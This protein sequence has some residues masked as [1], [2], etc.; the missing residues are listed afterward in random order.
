MFALLSSIISENSR[1]RAKNCVCEESVLEFQ[2]HS[3]SSK[4]FEANNLVTL[5]LS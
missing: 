5:L 3:G 4:N 2:L 1:N